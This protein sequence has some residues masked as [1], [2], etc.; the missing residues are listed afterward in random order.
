MLALAITISVFVIIALLR[1]GVIA[2]YS[3]DGFKLWAKVGFFKFELLR[4]DKEK[5]PKKKKKPKKERNLKEMMPGSLSE[6]MD[7]LKTV[8]NA[9]GRL[10]RRLLIKQ[11]TLYYTSAGEDPAATALIFGA[12]NAVF[13]VIVPKI[14]NNFRIRRL[15]LRS[16]FDF[17]GVEQKIYAKIIISIAVWEVFYVLFALFPLI[18][19]AFKKKTPKIS[20]NINQN[21]RKDGEDNGKSSDQRIDGNND[22]ENEGND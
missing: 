5:K 21:D 10:K 4:D 8:L 12:A 18:T 6:F 19:S 16:W 1:F 11:L 2:E 22:A 13:G 15:D 7:M 17:C 9:L 14:R 20:D 3:E